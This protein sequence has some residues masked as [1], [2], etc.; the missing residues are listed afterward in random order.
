MLDVFSYR[1]NERLAKAS[2]PAW[3]I[4]QTHNLDHFERVGFPV[5]VETLQ[6]LGPLLDTMQEN[7]FEKYMQELGGLTPEE[8]ALLVDASR[9]AVL[10]Q[11][12]FFPYRQPVVP[13]STLLSV[14]RLY[15]KIKGVNEQFESV[16]EIGP[17][18]GYLS[19]FLKSHR[20]LRNYS[21]IEACESFYLLQNLV[22][23][24]VFG[25]ELSERAFLAQDAKLSD[26][27]S[28][29]D[30]VT[31]FA[32]LANIP[33]KEPRCVHYPWWR[34]GEI[35][36]GNVKFQ[37][38]TSNANL[39]EFGKRALDEYLTLIHTALLP[40]GVFVAQCLGYPSQNTAE[41]LLEKTWEKGFG[42]LA[43]AQEEVT[44]PPPAIGSRSDLYAQ[45]ADSAPI[46]NPV[47][48]TVH[49]LILVRAGHPLFE[50]CRKKANYHP[51]FI[52]ANSIVD[53]VLFARPARRIMYTKGQLVE[54]TERGFVS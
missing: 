14:L 1:M 10:F 11:L 15:N 53:N 54:D 30:P 22:N 52:G 51:K 23:L 27:F 29:D 13:A 46:S 18:C 31:E 38:V 21:Q 6:E 33:R 36:G 49:N 5:R 4:G 32:P 8:Y 9:D 2:L 12:R 35:V 19:F 43:F 37:I 24:H 28:L 26:Y 7:R 25:E 17:G 34:I 48:F 47:E 3:Q 39:L 40:E 16:L 41:A 20:A 50:A 42:L 44:T 45:I